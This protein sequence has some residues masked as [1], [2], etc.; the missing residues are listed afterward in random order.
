MLSDFRILP[1]N[2]RRIENLMKLNRT[3]LWQWIVA[4]IV[5][6]LLWVISMGDNLF[7]INDTLPL[8]QPSVSSD[9]IVLS[10]LSNTKKRN[11]LSRK[12]R[13]LSKGLKGEVLSIMPG[14]HPQ[15]G[16]T[17]IHGIKLFKK[18]K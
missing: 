7:E 8:E 12:V 1:K 11:P 4:L 2:D 15:A 13:L 18:W 14:N 6:L 10:S 3:H 17:T 9:F 16:R 5:S